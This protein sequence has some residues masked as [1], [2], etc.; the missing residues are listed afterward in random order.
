VLF[1]EKTRQTWGSS[2]LY[3]QPVAKAFDPVA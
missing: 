1:M 2:W 3:E